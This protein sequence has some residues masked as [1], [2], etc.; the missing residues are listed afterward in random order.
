MDGVGEVDRH[1]FLSCVFEGDFPNLL[2]VMVVITQAL[3]TPEGE[4]DITCIPLVVAAIVS[5]HQ[6]CAADAYSELFV[7]EVGIVFHDVLQNQLPPDEDHWLG[8][9][10]GFLSESCPH[11]SA[12]DQ[13]IHG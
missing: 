2:T 13:D 5:D 9:N 8:T 10:P 11:S 1:A 4:Y 3:L 12:Q 7:A 6:A